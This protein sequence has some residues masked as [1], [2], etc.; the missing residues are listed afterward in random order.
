MS[1]QQHIRN[2]AAD[3][4]QASHE[5]VVNESFG[6]PAED[7]TDAVVADAKD[8][9]VAAVESDSLASEPDFDEIFAEREK[10]EP[11]HEVREA[12]EALQDSRVREK[13][14]EADG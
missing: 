10:R 1:D 14:E 9:P 3:E 6:E 2:L 13:I 11:N 8:S 4:A 5:R 12:L 7:P